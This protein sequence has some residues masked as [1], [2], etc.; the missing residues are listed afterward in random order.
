M[1]NALNIF[2][3][4]KCP[5]CGKIGT[6]LCE[7]CENLI[8]KYQL[9][10]K[11][12]NSYNNKKVK[13]NILYGFKYEGIIRKLLIDYKFNDSSYLAETFVKIMSKNEK[14]CNFLKNYDIIIPVPLHKNRKRERGYNQTELIAKKL[15]DIKIETKVLIKNKNIKPQS[16]KDLKNRIKD[17]KG[18]YSLQNLGKIKDK[19][20][21]LFDDI[22]TTGST[23]N[24]CIKTLSK[25][26][27]NIGVLIIAKDLWR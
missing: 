22:Y 1:F 17:V 19:K 26:T 25:V 18:V 12:M 6:V 21:L 4:Q 16:K 14:I 13:V 10:E 27:D 8:N 20:V 23:I 3:P 11:G 7:E 5:I 2:F 9:L 24:E 15:K